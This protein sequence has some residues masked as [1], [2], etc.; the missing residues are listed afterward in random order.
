MAGDR[1]ANRLQLSHLFVNQ[2]THSDQA[3]GMYFSTRPGVELEAQAWA[4]V[5]EMAMESALTADQLFS[6]RLLD[7]PKQVHECPEPA[8]KSVPQCN[9]MYAGL[10][11]PACGSSFRL[12]TCLR[13]RPSH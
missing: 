3:Q 13:L 8:V 12:W 5:L 11:F 4:A 7:Q 2:I 1:A 9:L 10:G 6:A